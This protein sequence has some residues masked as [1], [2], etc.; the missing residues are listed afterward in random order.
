[1]LP[2]IAYEYISCLYLFADCWQHGPRLWLPRTV[3]YG[4]YIIKKCLKLVLYSW[5]H[6]R[7]EFY[8][9][10]L[11]SA[12]QGNG[13]YTQQGC[14]FEALCIHNV[15]M[16]YASKKHMACQTYCCQVYMYVCVYVCVCICT[17]CVCVCVCVFVLCLC[18]CTMCRCT[19]CI[20]CTCVCV[21]CVWTV[22]VCVCV[23]VCACNIYI[24]IYI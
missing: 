22:C 17:L 24:Y 7:L 15:L 2:I 1:M 14:Y 8:L 9:W 16:A 4:G 18:I 21:P 23:C 20:L 10:L 6:A 19:L 11:L 5:F 13:Q 12:L 3:L